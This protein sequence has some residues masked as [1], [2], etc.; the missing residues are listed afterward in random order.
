M[1]GQGASKITHKNVPPKARQ[2]PSERFDVLQVLGVFDWGPINTATTCIDYS[3]FYRKFG[4]YLASYQGAIQVKQY[5]DGGGRLAVVNRVAHLTSYLT[6]RTLLS[7]A[8]STITAQTGAGA[9]GIQNTLQIQGKYEGSRGNDLRYVVQNATRDPAGTTEYFDLLIY[10]SGVTT[11]E[12]WYRNVT[13][14]ST[15]DR[16]VED[17]VNTESTRSDWVAVTDLVASGTALQRRPANIA[18]TALAGGN[19]GLTL[20]DNNDYLGDSTYRTGVHAFT[21]VD[22]GDLLICPDEA[23][24]TAVQDGLTDYC[25]LTVGG[26]VMFI[27]DV[28]AAADRTAVV[29]HATGL[30]ASEFRTG[31]YWPRVKV[32]NPDTGIYGKG[33]TIT[34]C[35]GGSIAGRIA[36][37]SQQQVE[38][39]FSQPGNEVYGLLY[40]VVGLEGAL[41]TRHE[42]LEP[43]VRDY[44]TDYLVN[45]IVEG[46]TPSQGVFGVWADDVQG[47]KF[48]DANFRSV[49]EIHGVSYLRKQFERFLQRHRTQGNTEQRRRDIRDVFEASLMGWTERGAFAS[50]DVSEAFYVNTDPEGEGLN[51]ALVQASQTLRVLVGVATSDPARFID[52]MFTKDKRAVESYIQQKLGQ[53]K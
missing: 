22:D 35:A 44:V 41:D 53:N 10:L 33:D 40:G 13:M 15:D 17:V 8:Q 46:I 24:D 25:E 4:R 12:E 50:K 2:L 43:S 39:Q 37:N 3:D 31:V 1:A 47:G 6:A 49:G 29:A 48:V 5:F 16:Y 27:T 32:A 18:L 20:L 11:P 45:P 34:I 7:A 14:D 9:Y 23:A 51:N 21:S 42:V 19:D 38:G 52:L 36:R 28:P 26:K 30:T